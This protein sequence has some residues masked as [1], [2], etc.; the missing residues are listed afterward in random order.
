M[1][2]PPSTI[3]LT[4]SL[5]RL[6]D[7]MAFVETNAEAAGVLPAKLSGLCLAVEEAFVN[8]CSYAFKNGLGEVELA[9]FPDADAF[10]L[11][12]VDNGQEFN[13]LS[14]PEPDI[15]LPLEQRQIGG[16]GVHFIRNYSDHA[17]WRREN[18]RNILRLT[19]N[20]HEGDAHS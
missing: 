5:D 17:D 13:Q 10:V 14:V 15:S 19:F 12:I 18:D 3:K 20:L 2:T 6:Q 9:C 16:L 4:A 7:V 1:Y 11:E 8:I